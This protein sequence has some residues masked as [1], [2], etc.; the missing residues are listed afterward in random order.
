MSENNPYLVQRLG[1]IQAALMAQ[2]AAGP[3]LPSAH[4]GSER[5]SFL[6][7]FL[8]K[9]FPAHRR[10]AT[11]TITDSLG[12]RSGQVDIAIEYGFVPSFP[13][14][15]TD[16]RLLLAESVAMVIEVKSD[17]SAQWGEVC[18]TTRGVRQ[19]KRKLNPIISMGSLPDTIPVVAVGYRGHGTIKGLRQRL[20]STAPDERPDAA[21][22]VKSGCFYGF[23][24][25][26]SGPLG[27]YALCLGINAALS[28]LGFAAPDLLSYVGRESDV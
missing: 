24:V 27:L 25:T 21:L 12:S 2:Y 23:D 8:Q 14:P 1:A 6:R 5:E 13:M 17:L 19:L 3:G 9:V 18:S 16:E 11:G 26:T 28:I 15:S 7:E 20:E 4:A 22:V 10:F